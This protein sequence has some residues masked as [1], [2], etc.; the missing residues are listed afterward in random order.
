MV[1]AYFVASGE[2]RKQELYRGPSAAAAKRACAARLGYR[3]I[4]SAYSYTST[5]DQ[6]EEGE[7]FCRRPES[8]SEEFDVAVILGSPEPASAKRGRG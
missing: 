3:A 7:F 2:R 6:G 8:H 4:Q 5:T 1:V